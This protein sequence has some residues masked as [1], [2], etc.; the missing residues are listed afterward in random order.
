MVSLRDAAELELLN[1]AF[2][3]LGEMRER[4]DGLKTIAAELD[5]APFTVDV[6]TLTRWNTTA[7]DRVQRL[8]KIKKEA[9]EPRDADDLEV[10]TS[11][12]SEEADSRP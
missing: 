4:I 11:R 7:I 1:Q 8:R 10:T 5:S 6:N 9:T 2:E 12:D 3:L